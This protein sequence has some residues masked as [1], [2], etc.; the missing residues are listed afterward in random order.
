MSFNINEF[1]SKMDT[2]GGPALTSLFMV[3]L[4]GTS[5]NF[6]S[7]ADI[8]FFCRSATL[9]GLNINVSEYRSQTFG[10]P[11]S[12][13]ISMGADNL[14]AVFMLD[15]NHKILSFFHEWMQNVINYDSKRNYSANPR[16][17]DHLSYEINYKD[18]YT[19]NMAIKHFSTY[20]KNSFYECQLEGVYPTQVGALN[21][22]W[23]DNA[24]IASLPVSF[25]YSKINYSGLR[26]GIP[27]ARG[28][29]LLE[30]FT[31]YGRVRNTIE[32]VNQQ[33]IDTS[34]R[35]PR[36]PFSLILRG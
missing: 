6:I 7:D 32:R 24:N 4:Y 28:I 15:S 8:K 20:N 3:E 23:E 34:I 2:F 5:S 1:K 29:G 13:P 11:E 26:A 33:L 35:L 31:R 18:N 17:S 9:P 36:D 16:D 30:Y 21:L 12:I 14:N 25:S 19:V 10:F 22:S 27:S